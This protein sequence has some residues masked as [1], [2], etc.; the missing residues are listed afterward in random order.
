MPISLHKIE[1]SWFNV[2]NRFGSFRSFTKLRSLA[3]KV[4]Q[5]GNNNAENL[6]TKLVFILP[7]NLEHLWIRDDGTTNDYNFVAELVILAN[8]R[9]EGSFTR[10]KSISLECPYLFENEGGSEL[11][12]ISRLYKDVGINLFFGDDETMWYNNDDGEYYP[13]EKYLD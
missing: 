5:P 10:M 9:G 2:D 13:W 11:R 12:E 8:M 6:P 4:E 1:T 7:E 3:L